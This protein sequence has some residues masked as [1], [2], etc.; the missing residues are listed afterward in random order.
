MKICVNPLPF[1]IRV[2]YKTVVSD[3]KNLIIDLRVNFNIVEIPSMNF[4]DFCKFGE[5]YLYFL[6]WAEHLSPALRFQN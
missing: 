5:K 6:S 4:N 1:F 2:E 3:A